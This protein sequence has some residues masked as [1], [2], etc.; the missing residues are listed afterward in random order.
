[1]AADGALGRA[2]AAIDPRFLAME[3]GAR[4]VLSARCASAANACAS[5]PSFSKLTPARC[6]G[7]TATRADR[8]NAFALEDQ[9]ATSISGALHTVVR[10]AEIARAERKSSAQ[11]TPLDHIHRAM[12]RSGS[13]PRGQ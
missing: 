10:S 13:S 11:L 4:Y 7:P 2:G 1:M 12:P 5:A 8:M 9:I 6:S 3:V